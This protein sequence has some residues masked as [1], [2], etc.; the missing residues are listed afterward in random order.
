ME[1]LEQEIGLLEKMGV[2]FQFNTMV[3]RDIKF[4]EVYTAYDSVFMGI[5]YEKPYLIAIDGEDAKGSIQAIDFLR[6][7]NENKKP[8]LGHHVAVIGGGNV[9]MDAARVSRRF[10][11]EVTVLYRRRVV[12]MPSDP[13]EIEGSEQENVHIEAQSIPTRIIKDENGKVKGIEYLKA[14]MVTDSKGGRPKPVAIEGSETIR[15]VSTVI[16]A[17]G[18]EGY[19]EFR[20]TDYLE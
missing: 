6:D 3:G 5:G 19:F 7:V 14:E 17:I 16:G 10:G 11:A 13:E 2:V 1:M 9:A 18:Q 12:D 4:D 8:E 15:E 20:G